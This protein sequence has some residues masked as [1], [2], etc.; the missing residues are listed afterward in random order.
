MLELRHELELIKR[1]Q[2]ITDLFFV[3]GNPNIEVVD[4][5]T[6]AVST[7]IGPARGMPIRVF[8]HL[9]SERDR[10][11]VTTRTT[12][13]LIF[14]AAFVVLGLLL[15]VSQRNVPETVKAQPLELALLFS[16]PFVFL[17]FVRLFELGEIRQIERTLRSTGFV[18]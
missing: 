16:F 18:R 2:A 15:V 9:D 5:Y 4:E 14:P 11:L 3:E 8:V 13:M 17:F 6:L 12:R 7:G 10:L 1:P